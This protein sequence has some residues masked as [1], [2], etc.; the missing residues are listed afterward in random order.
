MD[1]GANQG[2]WTAQARGVLDRLGMP[3]VKI[4]PW[5][6]NKSCLRNQIPC[7]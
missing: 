7:R 1:I 5:N 2:N 4:M 3:F 6:G